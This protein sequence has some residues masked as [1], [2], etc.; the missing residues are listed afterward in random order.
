MLPL[1]RQ[2]K[3]L[4]F[5]EK[6]GA[7]RCKVGDVVLYCRKRQYVLHRIIE[8]RPEDYVIMGDNCT[9]KEYGIKDSDILAV[10]TSFIRNGKE[11][12]VKELAYKI[13]SFVW[14]KTIPIRIFL[15]LKIFPAVKRLMT[16]AEKWLCAVP[17]KKK[18]YVVALT[19]MQAFAGSLGVLYALFFRNGIDST[20]KKDAKN[21]RHYIFLIIILVFVQI[22]VSMII[23]W[24]R[25]L[26]V[27]EIENTFKSRLLN[28]IFH[29]DYSSVSAIHTAEWLNRLTSDTAIVASGHVEILPGLAETFVR[30]FSALAMIV[31]MEKWLAYILIPSGI[32]F[33]MFTFLFRKV[34]RQL[35]KNIQEQDG[36]LKIFLQE[37]IGSLMVIKSFGAEEQ[38]ELE[39]VGKMTN[40]KNARMKRNYVSNFCNAGFI[41]VM[42]G[43]YL[44]SVIYCA[45]GIMTGT[46]TYGTLTAIMQLI[47]QI[48]APF[49]NIS[50]YLP[51]YYAM[52]ASAER[53]ME[54]EKFS[55][56]A[57]VMNINEIQKFYKENFISLGLKDAYFCYEPQKN[58]LDGLS[59]EIKKGEYIAFTG[60]SGC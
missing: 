58:I 20:V 25:E 17:K 44:M 35:H 3:D 59:L 40:H 46:V 2:G 55:D 28:K 19:L 32:I 50:G 16:S 43:I 5:V 48:Q 23:R 31:L 47:G 1:L 22:S 10:M 53:L 18:Y 4:F 26:S 39:A 33:I 14:L 15:R 54:E 42:H 56:E 52:T 21:F 51:K 27:A 60:H 12:N 37:R 29:K 57:E 11:H 6:K 13:Y 9:S 36:K 49:A 24:L 30:L 45:N 34:L 38:T 41:F 8:V 7:E